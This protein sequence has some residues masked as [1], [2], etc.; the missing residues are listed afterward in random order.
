M[1]PP[2]GTATAL[3]A[4]WRSFVWELQLRGAQK[5]KGPLNKERNEE[6]ATGRK[7]RR[8]KKNK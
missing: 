7:R 3:G 5:E 1:G 2:G 8:V 4:L 6:K